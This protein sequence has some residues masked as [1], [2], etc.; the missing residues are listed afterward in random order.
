MEFYNPAALYGLLALPLLI[1]P[2]LIRRKPRRVVFS[3][4]LLLSDVG[5]HG[6]SRPWGKIR[7]PWIFFVQLLLLALLILALSEPVFSVRPTQIAVI[8]DNSASMQSME[9]GKTRFALAQEKARE[10]VDDLGAGGKVD[11]FLLTPRLQKLRAAPMTPAEA[12]RAIGSLEA[13]DL[14]E[15]P[16]D[17][18]Q[19]LNQLAR[20]GGYQRVYLIT[21]RLARGQTAAI[22]MIS[23]GEPQANFAMIGFQVRRPSLVDARLEAHVEVANFSS[24]DEKLKIVV[25]TNTATLAGREISIPAG[26][27]A[28]VTFDRVAEHPYYQAEIETRDPLML[29]N[30]RFTVAPASRNLRILGIS[31]QPKELAS[32]KSI[33][34]VQLDII[35]PSQYE[36]AEHGLYGLEIFHYAAPATLP[37]NPALFILPPESSPLVD[38][39]APVANTHVS[40]WREPHVLTRYVNF[41]LFR[42]SYTRPLK[43]QTVG[44]VLIESPGGALAFATEREGLR[45][46]T[47]GFD[48]LPYLGRQNLPMSIFT[49]NLLDW[50]FAGGRAGQATGEPIPLGSIH[51]GDSLTTPKGE[52]I[53]LK[54]GY[55]HFSATFYQGIYQRSRGAEREFSALNL[56]DGNE[57]DLRAPLSI[58][59][60]GNSTASAGSS[61]LFSF[62]PYLLVVSLL[63]LFIEWFVAPSMATWNL[64]RGAKRFV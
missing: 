25:K 53:P 26:K 17:Y 38:L 21:D 45:Y 42:P 23:V 32:L 33:P 52:R 10:V 50:F 35:A 22:K 15:P 56:Q 27:T 30:H 59:L 40:R 62:W 55:S 3:S 1:V 13:Y 6:S 41:S 11:L 49:L 8:L 36:K 24:K 19:T 9:N 28:S 57:S 60:R 7:L 46:L 31:P 18:D 47:L 4:L 16:L 12:R 14:G 43:P 5:E 58:D 64:R 34:G 44:D 39:G 37:I 61:V 48:P 20:E 54:A 51:A 2:Y 29:D 63:L